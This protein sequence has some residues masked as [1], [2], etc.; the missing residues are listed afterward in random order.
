MTRIIAKTGLVLLCVCVILETTVQRSWAQVPA[1]PECDFAAPEASEKLEKARNGTAIL[2]SLEEMRKLVRHCSLNLGALGNT[3][4][5]EAELLQL[6]KRGRQDIYDH[7]LELIKLGLP[8]QESVLQAVGQKAGKNIQDISADYVAAKQSIKARTLQSAVSSPETCGP[9]V[10]LRA[11]LPPQRNQGSLSW[12]YAHVMADLLSFKFGRTVSA[13]ALAHMYY[14]ETAQSSSA[15]EAKLSRSPKVILEQGSLEGALE[16]SWKN[17]GFCTELDQ[18]SEDFSSGPEFESYV[19]TL[20]QIIEIHDRIAQTDPA[21]NTQST[22]CESERAA[23]DRIFPALSAVPMKTVLNAIQLNQGEELLAALSKLSCPNKIKPTQ[24]PVLQRYRSDILVRLNQFLDER[25]PS[26]I[27]YDSTTLHDPKGHPGLANHI[28]LVVGRKWNPQNQTCEFL[29]R[30]SYGTA[31]NY[32]PY[33]RCERGNI[34]VPASY[35]E[36]ISTALYAM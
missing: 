27:H 22:L 36:Q 34:W 3:S 7:G 21:K 11:T 19:S 14:A 31:C 5:T 20:H 13:G 6:E 16:A 10:D 35:I 23:L 32:S 24:K 12:C 33:F 8:V 15:S 4:T 29:I 28:S 25:K 26:A 30:N 2:H 9:P 17:G 1:G 18:R